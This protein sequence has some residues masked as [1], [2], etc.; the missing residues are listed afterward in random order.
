MN[1][2]LHRAI[3]A[4]LLAAGALGS[5]PV[6]ADCPGPFLREVKKSY[7]AAQA[8]ER[9][10][11]PES[12]VY[13][14]RHAIGQTCENTN[15]Y[16]QDAAKRAATLS[17][18]LG[19]AAEKQGDTQKAYQLYEA[20]GHYAAADR[21]FMVGVRKDADE[22][23]TYENARQHFQSWGHA[24]FQINNALQ[25][26]VSG[27]YAPDPKLLAEIA[28]MPAR[29]IDNTLRKEAAAFNEQY[30]RDYVQ[31]VQTGSD[32]PTD[33]AAMQRTIA[34]QQA[35][36]QKWQGEDPIKISIDKVRLLGWWRSF[37][38]D[39]Q[40]LKQTTARFEQLIDQRAETLSQHYS[41]APELL[42]HA[43]SYYSLGDNDNARFEAQAARVR[44]QAVKLADAA[45]VKQRFALAADYYEVAGERAAATA[46]RN[47]GNQVA[48]QKLKPSID[49]AKEQAEFMKQQYGDPAKVQAMREQAEAMRKSLQ[50]QQAAAKQSNAKSAAELE[51]ELGL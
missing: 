2:L 28:A 12:A 16:E 15:P 18:S 31:L 10:G 35:F 45:L 8:Y 49:A 19:G 50:R 30:L 25:I 34:A 40:M 22:P 9:A 44:A 5:A 36:G 47:R 39:D 13:A 4:A 27:A 1:R 6:L 41:G 46:A 24:S 48:M 33:S 21:V 42:E 11:N 17:L 32:D 38:G 7:E 51:K 23:N 37:T 26:K 20:G 3:C 43:I 29:A 14:F